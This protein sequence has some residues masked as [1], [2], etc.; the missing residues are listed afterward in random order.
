MQLQNGLHLPNG[1]S[2]HR[3]RS[4]DAGR[5]CV[6]HRAVRGLSP[7]RRNEHLRVDGGSGTR[8][9]RASGSPTRCGAT[10]PSSGRTTR[11]PRSSTRSTTTATGP[12]SPTP[13][14][15]RADTQFTNEGPNTDWNPVWD[16]PTGRFDGGWT[17]EYG[18]LVGQAP[19]NVGS[20]RP[21]LE[22]HHAPSEEPAGGR[23]VGDRRHAAGLEEPGRQPR[24]ERRQDDEW[25]RGR[26]G[27]GLAAPEEPLD[28]VQQ[29]GRGAR[30]LPCQPLALVGGSPPDH[31]VEFDEPFDVAALLPLGQPHSLPHLPAAR[32]LRSVSEGMSAASSVCAPNL[33]PTAIEHGGAEG[34]GVDSAGN[35][36]GR[37]PAGCWRGLCRTA[38][39]APFR[40]RP[41]HVG[42]VAYGFQGA[43]GGRSLAATASG[44]IGTLVL[45]ADFAAG[46]LSDYRAMP[47]HAGHV[48]HLLELAEGA[49]E[50]R[51]GLG[52]I[53]AVEALVSHLEQ[54]AGESGLQQTS[55]RSPAHLPG[56]GPA[57]SLARAGL[58]Q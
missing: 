49:S 34:V 23:L 18:L 56:S 22:L 40:A 28:G 17:V 38:R 30:A 11:S 12:T 55:V 42:H 13:L 36:Y 52:M 27:C 51:L 14:G 53:S 5:R 2:C 54:A 39:P 1:S 57:C 37:R 15:A 24:T 21:V 10:S 4:D 32:Q 41:A 9:P 35:V 26:S 20:E 3:L 48:L 8:R 58:A 45:H 29:S 43:P 46:G 16:V 44:A 7:V 25:Q 6:G 31:R 50:P 47:R 19:P 33:E